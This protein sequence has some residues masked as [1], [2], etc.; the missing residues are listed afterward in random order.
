MRE[1]LRRCQDR[2]RVS[3]PTRPSLPDT[4]EPDDGQEASPDPTGRGKKHN[5]RATANANAARKQ[6]EP[7][8]KTDSGDTLCPDCQT[9]TG[10]TKK[11][12]D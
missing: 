6:P 5:A 4:E 7:A 2:H 9:A 3:H 11:H 10:C 1:A 12:H 8:T